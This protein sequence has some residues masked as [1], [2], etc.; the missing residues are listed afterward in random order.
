VIVALMKA[1]W[2]RAILS[3]SLM[4]LVL[5]C[6]GNRDSAPN[7][8]RSS[9]P[10]GWKQIVLSDG[11]TFAVPPDAA[12]QPVVG[13]DS[14]FGHLT[15]DGYE[16][17]Y[18]YG[19]FPEDLAAHRAQTGFESSR[20]SVAGGTGDQVHFVLPESP[21][22]QVHMLQVKHEGNALTVSISCRDP[23]QCSSLAAEVFGSVDIRRS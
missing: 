1:R 12:P 17:T 5:G 4:F 19:R 9:V 21:L 20:R 16:M 22:P 8:V 3:V 6:S 7:D 14:E 11:V 13:V 10:Q 15:G 18:D 23:D 2:P